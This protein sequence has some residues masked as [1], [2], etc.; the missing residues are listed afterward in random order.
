MPKFAIGASTA[1]A[2][3]ALI[4]AYIMQ[5]GFGL[6]P[7]RLCYW[8]R[9]PYMVVIAIGVIALINGR[10]R[11][12]LFL[13]ALMFFL[14]FGIAAYHA[15]I[16]K[17][18]FELPAGCAATAAASMEDLMATLGK[19]QAQCDQ[20]AFMFLGLTLSMWNATAALVMAFFA[21]F[22]LRKH[23]G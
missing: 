14:D 1:F 10:Y 13:I 22:V 19:P 11:A 12:G 3:L 20:P 5:Y 17:G 23:P 15:G 2:A 21:T 7:C 16:E 18:I 9:Y 4:T 6:E 8:Q